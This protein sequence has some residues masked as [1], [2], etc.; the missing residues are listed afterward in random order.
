MIYKYRGFVITQPSEEKLV[1]RKGNQSKAEFEVDHYF[2]P[3]ELRE[4]VDDYGDAM[5]AKERKWEHKGYTLIQT[6]YNWHFMIYDKE[7]R[8]VMHASC[9]CPLTDDEAIENI[10]RLIR[11]RE[12]RQ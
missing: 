8:A 9:T 3:D 12:E 4:F 7:G 1:I 11:F 2:T 6:D 10:E 5:I